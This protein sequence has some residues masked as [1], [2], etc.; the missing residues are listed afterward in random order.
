MGGMSPNIFCNF[1]SVLQFH[2]RCFFF[3]PWVRF[4]S[5]YLFFLSL[6]RIELLCDSFLDKSMTGV[7]LNLVS[8]WC[9]QQWRHDG[10]MLQC[11]PGA[12]LSIFSILF[13]CCFSKEGL[14]GA[15]HQA[16]ADFIYLHPGSWLGFSFPWPK[17]YIL[18]SKNA[19]A[20]RIYTNWL[21]AYKT[22]CER[23]ERC[24]LLNGS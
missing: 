19:K 20:K 17:I 22:I 9:D 23:R 7:S 5:I 11:L 12:M 18:L 4:T 3:P 16:L 21:P 24:L 2:C 6:L 1:F 10:A 13:L 14:P 8:F 15:S